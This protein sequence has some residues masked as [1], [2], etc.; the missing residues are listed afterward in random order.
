MGLFHSVL[1]ENPPAS[2]GDVGL[3]PGSG[4]SPG[5]GHGIPLQYSWLGVDRGA[6]WAAVHGVAKSRTRLSSCTAATAVV[7]WRV[8]WVAVSIRSGSFSLPGSIPRCCGTM[9]HESKNPLTEVWCVFS[10]ARLLVIKLHSA[11]E[12]RIFCDF[13]SSFL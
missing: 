5:G 12:Y 11:F 10:F 4:S 6:W 2:A 7:L 8:S 3:F 13:K 1:V 9:V